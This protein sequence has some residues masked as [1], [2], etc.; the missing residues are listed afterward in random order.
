MLTS[1]SCCIWYTSHSA[2][3]SLA[4]GKFEW[5]FRHVIFRDFSDWCW[6]I[7]CGIALIWMS[8]D[9]TDYQSTLVQVMAWH[10]QATCHYL[11]QSWPS[12]LLPYGITRPGRPQWVN[13][14][15]THDA[16]G[17][18]RTWSTLVQ[19]IACCL[20]SNDTIWL[21]ELWQCLSLGLIL[22]VLPVVSISNWFTVISQAC[23]GIPQ[24]PA[25]QPLAQTKYGMFVTLAYYF[26][27]QSQWV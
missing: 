3:N 6:G 17:C 14:L 15:T 1:S 20:M 16:I 22:L 21:I 27:V 24:Q 9:F 7:S 26:E 25:H 23:G 4:P 19:L 5:N 10:H 12:S 13:P 2:F 18:H 8:P 11:S